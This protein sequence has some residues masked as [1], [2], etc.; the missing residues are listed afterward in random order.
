MLLHPDRFILYENSADV[1]ASDYPNYVYLGHKI[2][3]NIIYILFENCNINFH[4]YYKLS[5][6]CF[7]RISDQFF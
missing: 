5:K 1:L 6:W 4:D 3:C 7:C 2:I